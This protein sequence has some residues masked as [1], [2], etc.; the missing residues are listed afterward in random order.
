M[1]EEEVLDLTGSAHTFFVVLPEDPRDESATRCKLT[2][3]DG[4][5]YHFPAKVF[6]LSVTAVNLQDLVG[7][8][9]EPVAIFNTDLPNAGF[10]KHAYVNDSGMIMGLP[11]NDAASAMVD[12]DLY[13]PVVFE[14]GR[15]MVRAPKPLSRKKTREAAAAKTGRG[16]R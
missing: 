9:F 2:L 16:S 7:G 3:K 11:Y 6:P 15:G 5:E 4:K 1:S 10:K 8:F 13:G 12:Y 14:R